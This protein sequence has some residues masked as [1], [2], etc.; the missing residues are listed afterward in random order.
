MLS[1]AAANSQH[2]YLLIESEPNSKQNLITGS[3]ST[4]TSNNLTANKDVISNNTGKID[5]S[6]I[7]TTELGYLN[8]LTDNITTLLN[9]NHL[10]FSSSSFSFSRRVVVVLCCV[11]L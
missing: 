11:V 9:I 5:V 1:I 2:I 10:T 6:T 3:A 8:G 4:I 7:G